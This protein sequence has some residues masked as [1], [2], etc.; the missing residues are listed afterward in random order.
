MARG[1]RGAAVLVVFVLL[2]GVSVL[3]PGSP[4]RDLAGGVVNAE[5]VSWFGRD[6]GPVLAAYG[7]S[8]TEADSR[9][10]FGL[11]GEE[12]W[13][14]HSICADEFAHGRNAAV[15]GETSE[16]VLARLRADDVEADVIVVAAGTNDL[17]LGIDTA[18]TL[19][20][21]RAAV[22]LASER[23]DVV[24]VTTVQ[25]WTGTDV[26]ELN[27]GVRELA[28]DAGAQVADFE[29]ILSVPGATTD[30]VHPTV[31]S[32]RRL[33]DEVRTAVDAAG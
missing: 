14:S 4:T 30:G 31:A 32:A 33:A 17:R 7:D 21:L 20:N 18:T 16:Q 3:I 13:Y 19:R 11:H 12:S 29:A 25:P 2:S 28:A 27:E 24:V 22:R 8:L 6:G 1:R 15:Q 9:A 23:A 10:H 5:C 26:G